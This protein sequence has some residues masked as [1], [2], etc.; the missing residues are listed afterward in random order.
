[1]ILIRKIKEWEDG[2]RQRIDEMLKRKA[3]KQRTKKELKESGEWKNLSFAEK[4]L[5]LKEAKEKGD[6]K[7]GA[8]YKNPN[9][10]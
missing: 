7:K 9:V 6:Y 1:M 10:K 5:T 4:R 8:I 3:R 2:I